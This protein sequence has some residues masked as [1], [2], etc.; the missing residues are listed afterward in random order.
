MVQLLL[1][2]QMLQQEHAIILQLRERKNANTPPLTVSQIRK[3]KL[4]AEL[5]IANKQK[6]SASPSQ[7]HFQSKTDIL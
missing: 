6:L 2:M 7:A 3:D 4:V 1:G 5:V